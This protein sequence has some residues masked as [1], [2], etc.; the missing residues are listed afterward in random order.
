MNPSEELINMLNTGNVLT[1]EQYIEHEVKIRVMKEV[2]DERFTAHEKQFERLD[3]KI[4]WILSL[5]VGGMVLPVFLH[6]WR[7]I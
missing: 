3:L 2:T 5:L 6:F 1:T 7:L 4:N